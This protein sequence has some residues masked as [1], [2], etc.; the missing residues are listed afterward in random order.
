M[1][2]EVETTYGVKLMA[3]ECCNCSVIFAMPASLR[4]KLLE[5]GDFFYCP[6]GHAQ[7]YTESTKQKLER[8]EAR[9]RREQEEN[10]RLHC[11]VDGALRKVSAQ[12]GVNTRLRK[13][14]HNG[15]CPECHRHFENLERHMKTKHSDSIEELGR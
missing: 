12:K 8:T 10:R 2:I 4:K 14:I 1:A 9:L 3:E 15:V 11:E 6:N 13:R 7:H 5:T